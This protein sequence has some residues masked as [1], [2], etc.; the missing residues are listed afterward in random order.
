MSQE[1]S[2]TESILFCPFHSKMH[3]WH[4]YRATATHRRRYLGYLWYCWYECHCIVDFPSSSSFSISVSLSLSH[5]VI[6]VIFHYLLCW[7][8]RSIAFFSVIFLIE[9]KKSSRIFCFIFWSYLSFHTWLKLHLWN[10][11]GNTL[12]S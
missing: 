6:N 12:L 7:I 8:H 3:W 2:A 5:S 11:I 1:R 4:H 10:V 9:K